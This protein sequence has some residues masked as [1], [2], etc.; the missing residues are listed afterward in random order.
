MLVLWGSLF[1][2]LFIGHALADYL[3]PHRGRLFKL[4]WVFSA[5]VGG[6]CLYAYIN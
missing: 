1:I 2:I 6:W 3:F 5:Y 4:L